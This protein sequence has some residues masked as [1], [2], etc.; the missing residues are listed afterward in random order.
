MRDES[1]ASLFHS[2]NVRAE[3]PLVREQAVWPMRCEEH[4]RDVHHTRV[5][6]T[7]RAFGRVEAFSHGLGDARAFVRSAPIG[8]Q[9]NSQ[10]HLSL[11][12]ARGGEGA[13]RAI[14]HRPRY[15]SYP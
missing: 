11:I 14:G 3:A 15:V 4:R 5:R 12:K 13:Q 10:S 8:H 6:A 2:Q 7:P 1:H 9:L